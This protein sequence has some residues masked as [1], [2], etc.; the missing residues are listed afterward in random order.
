MTVRTPRAIARSAWVVRTAAVE[1]LREGG[2]LIETSVDGRP[3]ARTVVQPNGSTIWTVAPALLGDPDVIRRHV[4]AVTAWHAQL[5]SVIDDVSGLLRATARWIAVA[6][7]VVSLAG[8]GAVSAEPLVR[9]VVTAGVY[10]GIR[11]ALAHTLPRLA[12]WWLRGLVGA[13]VAG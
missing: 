6:A 4:G 11:V 7:A 1:L 3:V 12:V 8:G 10:A 9:A 2:A 5:R 13:A